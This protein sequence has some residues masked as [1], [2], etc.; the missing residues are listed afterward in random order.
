MSNFSQTLCI[1]MIRFNSSW[2]SINKNVNIVCQ[3]IATLLTYVFSVDGWSQ[4]AGR[5]QCFPISL[6]CCL[7]DV[8]RATGADGCR[9]I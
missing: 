6:S 7:D 4:M 2:F 1:T 3:G 5:T 8:S 9:V